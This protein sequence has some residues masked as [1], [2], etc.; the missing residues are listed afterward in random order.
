MVERKLQARMEVYYETKN[1]NNSFHPTTIFRG[2]TSPVLA[3]TKPLANTHLANQSPYNLSYI[4]QVEVDEGNYKKSS[5]TLIAP[6]MLLTVAHGIADSY[7]GKV[8]DNTTIGNALRADASVNY[9]NTSQIY[10]TDWAENPFIVH[11]RYLGEWN[12]T[13]DVALVRITDPT[14]ET[15]NMNTSQIRLRVYKNLNQLRW[16][17]FTII[18]NTTNLTGRWVYETGRIT[19]VRSDGLLET[20]I[21]GVVGQSGSAIL[22]DGQIIGVASAI[23]N[24]K[25]LITPLTESMKVELFEPNGIYNVE[26]R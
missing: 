20:N 10:R 25:V 16:K 4:L 13:N 7:T 2:L 5:A 3:V 19:K 23:E 24:N 21:S 1:I 9:N 17:N 8:S 11:P 22:V 18:S 14:Q 15:S 26:V 6:N 12:R